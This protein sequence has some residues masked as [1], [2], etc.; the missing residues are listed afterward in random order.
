MI[1][2]KNLKRRRYAFYIAAIPALIIILSS[3]II[4]GKVIPGQPDNSYLPWQQGKTGTRV[5]GAET[6]RIALAQL[7]RCVYI[8]EGARRVDSVLMECNRQGVD[9]VCFPETYIPG[10]RGGGDDSLLPPP[11]QPAMEKALKDIQASCAK[12]KVAAIVGMEW[13]SRSGL[14]NRAFVISA[15][16]KVLGHQTKNQITPGGEERNYVPE[17]VRRLFYIKGVP[18]GIVICHEGWRYPETVR[19]AAVR[20]AKIVFQPQV[21][22][23]NEKGKSE[24][25]PWGQSYYEMA[26]VLRSKENSIYF[27]SVNECMG[28]QNSATSLID[29][30]GN[31]V[32]YL[33]CGTESIMIKDIDLK[34]AT[35]FYAG[36]YHPE[37]YKEEK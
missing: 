20:G 33:P 30:E 23:G 5:Q 21:T 10:L 9:I 26:M 7:R 6:L 32:A 34:K 16:G 18:F 3:F 4:E 14:E 27:A 13:V 28:R 31:L 11:D 19:W 2:I 15:E 22:G 29:P 25:K 17:D 12:Y 35:G 1:Q 37:R 8:S 36:R 24:P